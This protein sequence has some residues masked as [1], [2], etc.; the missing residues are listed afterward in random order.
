M[1]DTF[2]AW[3][4]LLSGKWKLA[5]LYQLSGGPLRWNELIHSFP[6]TAPNVLT[7][8]LRQLEDAGLLQRIVLSQKAPQVIAYSLTEDG[9]KLVPFLEALC[10]W[11][12]QF[13][14]AQT[15]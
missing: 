3:R 11:D 4:S 1:T 5:L 14:Q 9:R 6:D 10:Q 8:Q 15:G 13:R 7:R 12:T 2:L